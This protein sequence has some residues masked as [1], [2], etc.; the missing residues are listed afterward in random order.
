[1]LNH[2]PSGDCI[3]WTCCVAMG[4]ERPSKTSITREHDGSNDSD[5]GGGDGEDEGN[6]I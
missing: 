5:N 6:K 4:P 2:Q 3:G 1:M